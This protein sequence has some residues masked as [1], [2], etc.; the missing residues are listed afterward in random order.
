MLNPKATGWGG[1]GGGGGD[2]CDGRAE[3]S[4]AGTVTAIY[5][6]LSPKSPLDKD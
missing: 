5:C 6:S 4:T 3:W 1:G 2:F